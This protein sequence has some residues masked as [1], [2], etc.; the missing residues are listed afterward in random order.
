MSEH[1]PPK[2]FGSRLLNTKTLIY[3][4]PNRLVLPSDFLF[5]E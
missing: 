2:S 1:S 3:Q 5:S 4:K